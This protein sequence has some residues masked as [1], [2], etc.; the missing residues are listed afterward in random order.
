MI[1]LTSYTFAQLHELRDATTRE[2]DARRANE[3]V[4]ARREMQRIARSL[5]MTIDELLS[6][7]V[8]QTK[9]KKET[10]YRHPTNAALSWSGHGRKPRWI[11][12]LEAE[13][14]T[15]EKMRE[16]IE[17]GAAD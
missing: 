1:D 13:G 14:V 11:H 2:I 9:A 5:G 8:T 17:P 3:I 6:A 4:E 7:K 10:I 16:T 12:E 15:L